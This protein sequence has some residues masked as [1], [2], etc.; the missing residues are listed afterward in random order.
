VELG[1]SGVSLQ[2]QRSGDGV[3]LQRGPATRGAGGGEEVRRA[4]NR[5]KTAEERRS[6]ALR[7]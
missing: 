6:S 4:G 5:R 1:S 7:R 2:Q 3:P